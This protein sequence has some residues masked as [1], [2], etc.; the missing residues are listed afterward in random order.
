MEVAKAGSMT[1]GKGFFSPIAAGF[2]RWNA[3]K[4]LRYKKGSKTRR[5]VRS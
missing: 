1:P 5:P 4:K 3:T 2:L